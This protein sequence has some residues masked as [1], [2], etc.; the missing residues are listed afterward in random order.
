MIIWGENTEYVEQELIKRINEIR[1]KLTNSGY[2][3]EVL[4]ERLIIQ[5]INS[6]TNPDVAYIE[7]QNYIQTTL[8]VV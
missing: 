1:M 4:D 2:K 6:Y 5:L 7:N 8:E 3:T